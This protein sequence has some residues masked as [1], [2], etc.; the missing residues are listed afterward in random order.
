VSVRITYSIDINK[1]IT[2][3]LNSQDVENPDPCLDFERTVTAG[4]IN[5]TVFVKLSDYK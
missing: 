3:Q 5:D 4:E 2:S 1:T